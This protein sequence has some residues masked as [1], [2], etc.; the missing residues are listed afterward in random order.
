MVVAAGDEE[1]RAAD[2]L[3][4]DGTAGNRFS[5][6]ERGAEEIAEEDGPPK[7]NDGNCRAE[8]EAAQR[9]RSEWDR[10]A[11]K[12]PSGNYFA[13][14][15]FAAAGG[16]GDGAGSEGDDGV[17]L[18][19]RGS[20]QER[21]FGAAGD[22]ENSEAVHVELGMRGE[23]GERGFEIIERNAMEPGGKRRNAEVGERERGEAVAG[24][25]GGFIEIEAAAGAAEDD[26]DGKFC[27]GARW[28]ACWRDEKAGDEV[29]LRDVAGARAEG[30]TIVRADSGIFVLSGC[31]NAQVAG[32]CAGGEKD[33]LKRCG[34][35]RAAVGFGGE[36]DGIGRDCL[37]CEDGAAVVMFGGEI[38]GPKQA[39]R[40][41][42]VICAGQGRGGREVNRA[43][44]IGAEFD[45]GGP[46]AI[47]VIEGGGAD[48][49]DLGRL[50]TGEANA[51]FLIHESG[52]GG[53]FEADVG[54]RRGGGFDVFPQ[55]SDRIL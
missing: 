34:G 39:H 22:A 17:D 51:N 52:I 6:A 19:K 53:N 49:N 25:N 5:I 30:A 38:H 37:F 42:A 12:S 1:D 3:D 47:V 10:R 40:R 36:I 20:E 7:D 28:R 26:H 23:P 48:A 33:S 15:F 44:G 32:F 35:D 16:P 14:F 8:H 18:V 9:K 45:V 27:G 43:R 21:E 55:M 11:A 31:V 4:R 2:V 46:V 41:H 29:A 50:G 54:R 13:G 24:E